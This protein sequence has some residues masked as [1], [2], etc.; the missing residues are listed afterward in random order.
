MTTII[1]WAFLFDE[2]ASYSSNKNI[3]AAESLVS[4]EYYHWN[5]PQCPA[6]SWCQD[7]IRL[8]VHDNMTLYF[9]AIDGMNENDARDMTFRKVKGRSDPNCVSFESFKYPGG[10]IR[11]SG[12]RVQLSSGGWFDFNFDADS[13]F[14]VKANRYEA[15]NAAGHFLRKSGNSL[16]LSRLS[17]DSDA[18]WET[19]FFEHGFATLGLAPFYAHGG[20][21][22]GDDYVIEARG[23][24]TGLTW[25]LQPSRVTCTPPWQITD[26]P[27]NPTIMRI[28]YWCARSTPW[29]GFSP[30]FTMRIRRGSVYV[31][32]IE[33]G[34]DVCY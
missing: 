28:V 7:G 17:D 24:C 4:L 27:L 16:I 21:V 9:G 26:T 25:P 13:T 11:H 10:F 12:N 34:W 32:R 23:A 5:D 1:S 15:H 20:T 18:W 2:V 30:W 33:T 31:Y 6:G 29:V 8:R 19:I 22:E 14:C 3:Q